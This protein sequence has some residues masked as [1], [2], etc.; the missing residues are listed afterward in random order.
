MLPIRHPARHYIYYLIAQRVYTVKAIIQQME[1]ASLPLPA[2]Y[3]EDDELI[4]DITR[5]RREMVFPKGFNPRASEIAPETESWL[6]AWGIRDIFAGSQFIGTASEILIEPPIRQLIEMLL[7]SPMSL[8]DIA[9]RVCARFELPPQVLNARVLRAYSHYF[10]DPGA[11]DPSQWLAFVRK[12]YSAGVAEL[13]EAV[14][15]SPRTKAGIGYVISLIDRDPQPI[16]IADRYE[17]ASALAF[18]LLMQNALAVDRSPR[19]VYA[20]YTALTMM[21]MADE[22]LSKYRGTSSD[23]LHELQQIR[24]VYD[25]KPPLKI[26]DATFIQ[27]PILAAT[28]EDKDE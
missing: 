6:R 17:T 3:D 2:Y 19:R 16:D 12:Y 21:K 13:Y 22:E 1:K 18:S 27:R 15:Q 26:T 28:N 14:L 8:P 10:W 4:V 24:A 9:D 5:A 11:L 7:L 23:L 25:K 20:A